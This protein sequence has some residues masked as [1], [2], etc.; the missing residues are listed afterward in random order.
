MTASALLLGASLG[1][2]AQARATGFVPLAPLRPPIQVSL[3]C[4]RIGALP[5]IEVLGVLGVLVEGAL[6][7]EATEETPTPR[8]PR[9]IPA[10]VITPPALLEPEARP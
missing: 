3:T 8:H 5:G 1:T 6:H 9:T 10:P 4:A 7:R 2:C